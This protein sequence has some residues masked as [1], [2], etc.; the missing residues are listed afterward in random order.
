[1]SGA[2]RRYSR[3][4]ARVAP[5]RYVEDGVAFA[6]EG[7]QLISV[8]AKPTSTRD[9]GILI[10]VGGPQYRVGSHRQFVLLARQLAEAG[11]ATMRFDYRG[12]GDSSGPMRSFDE[13]GPDIG[14]AIGAFQRTCPAL[15]K[16]VLWGLCDA[17][18]AAL[19]YRQ[20]TGDP[21]VAGI[22]L[23]NPW[24]RSD[25]TLAK[26]QIK[27]YYADRILAK[28]FWAKLG[29]GEVDV[30]GAA[31]AFVANLIA[32]TT[33]RRD[34][35]TTTT[36]T[37]TVTAFQDRMAD[38]LRS[39]EGPVLLI[40]SGRDLTA[41][42]FLENAKGSLRWAGLLQGQRL[43]RHDVVDSDHTF[44]SAAWSK[45]VETCTLQWLL[46]SFGDT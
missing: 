30:V 34:T 40:M 19:T 29:R 21:R 45:E 46:R 41:K 15:T 11:I 39:F 27:H 16:I 1:V 10:V 32:A 12:M 25:A 44:S 36:A 28:D 20:A 7:E 4:T 3:D 8:I 42:E 9:I 26:T 38:G 22:V 13:I 6:C 31:R 5:V 14:A 2:H 43:D 35:A 24:V 18:S 23:A 17:A 33:K 37:T